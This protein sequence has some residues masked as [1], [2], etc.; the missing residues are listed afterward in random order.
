MY[1]IVIAFELVTIF[2]SLLLSIFSLE[3]RP[4]VY[5]A[6]IGLT[7]VRVVIFLGNSIYMIGVSK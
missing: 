3:D 7:C 4:K 5:L 6:F 1:I 2:L